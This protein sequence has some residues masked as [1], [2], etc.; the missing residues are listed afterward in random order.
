M[1]SFH[2]EHRRFLHPNECYVNP[3]IYEAYQVQASE[4]LNLFLRLR[5]EE[6]A[7]NGLGLYLMCAHPGPEAKHVDLNFVMKAKATWTEA[8]E[9]AVLEF[10]NA[11]QHTLAE[12]TRQA[13]I[14]VKFPMFPRQEQHIRET[15][16]REGLKNTLELVD[17]HSEECMVDNKTGQGLSNFTWSVHGN[18]L[19]QALKT[20]SEGLQGDTCQLDLTSKIMNAVRKQLNLLCERDFADGK[21]YITYTYIVVKRRP[22]VI[23]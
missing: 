9:N 20:W 12:L 15:L 1:S 6:L 19:R 2:T 22:R 8:F 3:A 13:L 4:D 17:I 21:T 7:D 16:S 10:I 23:K 5:A 11:G 18:S 14:A